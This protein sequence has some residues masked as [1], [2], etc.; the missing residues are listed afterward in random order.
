MRDVEDN[1]RVSLLVS[2]WEMYISVV[3]AEKQ[4]ERNGKVK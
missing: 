2:L 1:E 4:S 3:K